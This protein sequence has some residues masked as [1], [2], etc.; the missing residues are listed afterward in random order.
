MGF[1]EGLVV[2]PGQVARVPG[3]RGEQTGAGE[4]R[5]KSGGF[6]GLAPGYAT[7]LLAQ[8]RRDRPR[9]IDVSMD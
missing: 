4:E 1:R 9:R 6:H 3:M 2:R 8:T 7:K 5:E